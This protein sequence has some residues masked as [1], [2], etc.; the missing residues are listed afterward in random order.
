MNIISGDKG[1]SSTKVRYIPTTSYSFSIEFDYGREP[2]GMFTAQ[3][4]VSQRVAYQ[5]FNGIDTSQRLDVEV[6]PAFMSRY[7]GGSE[8]EGKSTSGAGKGDL[9]E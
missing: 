8:G 5:Y 1:C 9:L 3:I 4:G 7:T 6:N 2:I